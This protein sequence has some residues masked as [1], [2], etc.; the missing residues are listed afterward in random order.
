MVCVPCVFIPILLLL[1]RFL[2]Q[3]IFL[4][5]WKIK[6]NK[7]ENPDEN[8]APPEL[9]KTCENGVCSMGWKSSQKTSKTE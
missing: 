7:G 8:Q 4:K 2:L 3:P 5:L 9:V 1:W 6:S